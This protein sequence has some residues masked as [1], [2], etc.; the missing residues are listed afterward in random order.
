MRKLYSAGPRLPNPTRLPQNEQSQHGRLAAG[1]SM[2]R[3]H[4]AT[5]HDLARLQSDRREVLA[6]LPGQRAETHRSLLAVHR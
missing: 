1:S 3:R 4:A 6:E 2:P 5:P